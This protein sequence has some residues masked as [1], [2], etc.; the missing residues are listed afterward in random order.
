MY[1]T[2]L[3]VLCAYFWLANFAFQKHCIYLTERQ[4]TY[5][6]TLNVFTIEGILK[7]EQGSY[8][9]GK[10]CWLGRIHIPFSSM[11]D[12]IQIH[13]PKHL[14]YCRFPY[15]KVTFCVC[16]DEP[17]EN[18]SFCRSVSQSNLLKIFK[19]KTSW[20]QLVL[21]SFCIMYE[22]L[23]F[24]R[25]YRSINIGHEHN[26]STLNSL[27]HGYISSSVVDFQSYEIFILQFVSKNGRLLLTNFLYFR[28]VSGIV[29]GRRTSHTSL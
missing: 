8:C 21:R 18:W 23:T 16:G 7:N 4:I 11:F 25:Q 29:Q 24:I 26:F 14:K 22:F 1:R 6:D 3:N 10:Q 20:L 2:P 28:V 12:V 15:L 5:S 27:Y 17:L 19:M 13:V 9:N